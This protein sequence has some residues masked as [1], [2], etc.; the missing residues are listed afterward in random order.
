MGFGWLFIGYFITFVFQM[1][2]YAVFVSPLGIA[3]IVFS[4]VKLYKYCHKFHLIIPPSFI[5]LIGFALKILSTASELA[6]FSLPHKSIFESVGYNV[7]FVGALLFHIALM[8]AVRDIAHKVDLPKIKW[9]SV[10]NFVVFALYSLIYA[11]SLLPLKTI[12]EFNQ[13]MSVPYIALWL[14]WMILNLV[15]LF[16]CYMRICQ[17]GDED[18]PDRPSKI[19]VFNKMNDA[20]N[21]KQE[22]IIESQRRYGKEKS[23]KKLEK[24]RKKKKQ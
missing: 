17:E 11:V 2:P 21:K 18:M 23:Q 13:L 1:N 3:I 7:Y 9:N 12:A 8:L 14:T 16:S 22:Q 15:M 10:R 4:A 6:D 5:M 19:K 24:Q 20:L